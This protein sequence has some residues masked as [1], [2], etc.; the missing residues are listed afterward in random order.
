MNEQCAKS[1]W[2]K[3][4]QCVRLRREGRVVDALRQLQRAALPELLPLAYADVDASLHGLAGL[5]LWAHL[6]KL[7]DDGVA[8]QDGEHWQYAGPATSERRGH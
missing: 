3:H 6:L 4:E 2:A 1:A 5:A 8:L 7:L